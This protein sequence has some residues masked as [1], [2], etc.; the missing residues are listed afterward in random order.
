[1][2]TERERERECVCVCVTGLKREIDLG[3]WNALVIVKGKH[4]CLAAQSKVACNVSC[5]VELEEV[6]PA[7]HFSEII[8]FL[9]S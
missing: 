3:H 8:S 6:V 4:N 1:M 7:M 2:H 9:K 5:I